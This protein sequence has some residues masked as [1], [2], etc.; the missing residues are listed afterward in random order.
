MTGAKIKSVTALYRRHPDL[1]DAPAQRAVSHFASARGCSRSAPHLRY[2]LNQIDDFVDAGRIEK[3][4][5]WLGFVQG[6]LWS[7]G[8]YSI[9]ELADHNRPRKSDGQDQS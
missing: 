7:L 4:F 5:R 9:E 1:A 3:A 6:V 8:L 2:M